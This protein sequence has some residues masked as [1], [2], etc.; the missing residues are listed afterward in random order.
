MA[1][2]M[3]T[4]CVFCEIV[5]GAL[6][7]QV[8]LDNEHV[9]AFKDIHPAAPVHALVVPKKHITG[10]HQVTSEDATVLGHVLLT[11][12]NVAEMLGLGERGYRLVINEGIDGGQNV[13]H[14]HCHVL[15]GR[16]MAWP[17]G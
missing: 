16:A 5:R 10:V 7:A 13:A 17:P 12:R 3:P 14:L 6:P 15:G 1:A 11:A 2:L 9:T 4:Q 8:L